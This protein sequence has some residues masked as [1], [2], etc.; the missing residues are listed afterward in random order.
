M[1]KRWNKNGPSP[2]SSEV[3][4]CLWYHLIKIIWYRH[5]P[6]ILTL[7][8]WS[9]GSLW[10]HFANTKVYPA[11]FVNWMRIPE[12]ALERNNWM[13][14]SDIIRSRFYI[15]W[16]MLMKTVSGC[17]YVHFIFLYLVFGWILCQMTTF[18]FSLFVKYVCNYI[19]KRNKLVK[20]YV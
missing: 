2:S 19:Q 17:S 10:I 16:I 12:A 3:L 15:F 18:L 9:C 14:H 4:W 11:G 6:K 13:Q 8:S 5:H 7:S 20:N 1:D